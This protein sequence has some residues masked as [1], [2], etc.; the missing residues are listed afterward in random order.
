MQPLMGGMLFLHAA[1]IDE[2]ADSS[3]TSQVGAT[4]L[5]PIELRS[6]IKSMASSLFA[7]DREKRIRCP[8]FLSAIHRAMLLPRPPRPPAMMYDAFESNEYLGFE[9]GITFSECQPHFPKRSRI[10]TGIT[11]WSFISTTIFPM[12]CPL[13]IARN[14]CSS[15]E[16]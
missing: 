9:D 15:S 12:L 3:L 10:N 7:P 2:T 4:S 14:A 16:T 8:A 11:A 13:C 6:C 5:T 1:I